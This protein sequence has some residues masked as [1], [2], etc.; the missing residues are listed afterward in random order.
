MNNIQEEELVFNWTDIL[1][2]KVVDNGATFAF[3]YARSQKKPKS[4][5]LS[6]QFVSFFFT[7]NILDRTFKPCGFNDIGTCNKL[8]GFS[9]IF[10]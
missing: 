9:L 8:N 7:L 10:L 3:E 1:E 6:T 5:K 4:V 2:H